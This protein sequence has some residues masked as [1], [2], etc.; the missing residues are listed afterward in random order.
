MIVD[1]ARMAKDEIVV[2]GSQDE[3]SSGYLYK[4]LKDEELPQDQKAIFVRIFEVSQR[5]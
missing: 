4:M 5:S 2:V 3:S 1:N